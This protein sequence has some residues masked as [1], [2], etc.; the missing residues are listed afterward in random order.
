MTLAAFLNLSGESAV[1]VGGGPVALRRAR[2]LLNAGLRVR[3][4]AP[5]LHPDFAAL[6]VGH[7]PRPYRPG[8]VA[9]ARVVVAAT[10]SPEVNGAVTAEAQATGA[11]VNHAGD[12]ARGTLRFPAVTRRGG[13]E[14]AFTTGRELPLLAQALAERIAGLLPAPE[15][16]DAWAE[17]REAALTLPGTEREAAL[18]ALRADIRAAVGLEP[19][20]VGA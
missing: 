7:D 10:S 5:E 20:Q 3:V 12:A 13:V 14:V 11:L 9:G 4:V 6:P 15:Q 16:V 1:V 2:T 8:D 18:A 17:R 19:G